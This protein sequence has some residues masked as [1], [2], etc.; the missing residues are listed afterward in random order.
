VQ[1]LLQ[2]QGQHEE[3][4]GAGGDGDQA[5]QSGSET[6]FFMSEGLMSGWVAVR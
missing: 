1:P 2:E 5:P 3:Q 4:A 6:R